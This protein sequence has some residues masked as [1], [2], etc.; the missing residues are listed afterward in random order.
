MLQ[1][2]AQGEGGGFVSVRDRGEGEQGK[3]LTLH[4]DVS[5]EASLGDAV[6]GAGSV[7]SLLGPGE[8]ERDSVGDDGRITV[9]DVGEWSSVDEDGRTLKRLHESGLDR[10]LHQD[11][12]RTGR[13]DVVAGDGLA[14]LGE[15]NDHLAES[16]L[17]V[18]KVL[19]QG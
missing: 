18:L 14:G 11:G 16:L 9:G 7:V 17:H 4:T 6:T 10:V 3:A 5:S 13:T 1:N 2:S 19:G 8:L 12:E 15:C